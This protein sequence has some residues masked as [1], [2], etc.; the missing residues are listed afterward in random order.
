MVRPVKRP[1]LY[2]LVVDELKRDIRESN[3][4]PGDRLPPEH[5]LAASLGVSR[6]SLRQGLSVLTYLGVIESR[7]GDGIYLANLDALDAMDAPFLS[8]I[9]DRSELLE[10]IEVRRILEQ[11]IVDMAVN[12]ASDDDIARLEDMLREREQHARSGGAVPLKEDLKFHEQVAVCTGNAVLA[13]VYRAVMS[14]WSRERR[15]FVAE[16]LGEP[17]S[18]R[19]HWGLLDAIKNRDKAAAIELVS[20]HIDELKRVLVSEIS[21]KDS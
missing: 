14:K 2:E 1:A 15:R 13:Q 11:G 9:T 7:H 19:Q 17:S 10:L 3:R 20:M 4:K 21:S 5:Q 18:L 6:A 12:E 8:G 16:V